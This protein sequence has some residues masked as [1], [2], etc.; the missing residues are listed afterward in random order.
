MVLLVTRLFDTRVANEIPLPQVMKYSFWEGVQIAFCG[1][2]W[3]EKWIRQSIISQLRNVSGIAN[4]DSLA[5]SSHWPSPISSGET[6]HTMSWTH[7]TAS[8]INWVQKDMRCFYYL[9][10]SQTKPCVV[11]WTLHTIMDSILEDKGDVW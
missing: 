5:G 1:L 4:R 7:Y 3:L 9:V 2:F 8:A 11:F 6:E 10:I